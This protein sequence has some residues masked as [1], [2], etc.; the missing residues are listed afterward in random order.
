MLVFSRCDSQSFMRLYVRRWEKWT[1]IRSRRCTS[2]GASNSLR[3]VSRCQEVSDVKWAS[4]KTNI[5][6]A[7][8][9]MRRR[10]RRCLSLNGSLMPRALLAPPPSIPRVLFLPL[11]AIA[12][13]K[14]PLTVQ[15]KPRYFDIPFVLGYIAYARHVL[16]ATKL[17]GKFIIAFIIEKTARSRPQTIYSRGEMETHGEKARWFPARLILRCLNTVA[18]I[19]PVKYARWEFPYYNSS[20]ANCV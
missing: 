7:C 11:L 20:L 18:E 13:R 19:M 15:R 16:K 8:R 6:A 4:S 1:T 5:L 12:R 14:S 17:P 9:R 10:A 2:G 3:G